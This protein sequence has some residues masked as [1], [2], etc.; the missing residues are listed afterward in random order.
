MTVISGI[1]LVSGCFCI[2][3]LL[4]LA[5]LRRFDEPGVAE[6]MAANALAFAAYAL[7]ALA[8]QLP[9]PLAIEGAN[10]VYV[11]ANIAVL[12]GF[13][14]FDGRKVPLAVFATGLAVFVMTL[15][16]FHYRY[17]SFTARIVT[18]SAFHGALMAAIAVTVFRSRARRH[19]RY[20][21]VFAGMTAALL[22]VVDVV[23]GVVH[24]MQSG[25]ANSLLQPSAWNVFFILVAALVLPALTFGAMMMVHDRMLVDS[26]SATS[27]DFLTGAATRSVFLERLEHE[28]ARSRRAGKKL[29]VLVLGVE[30]L[31]AIRK[32]FGN[33][34]GDQVM[35]AIALLADRMFRAADCFSRI[36]GDEFAVLLPETGDD[37]ALS[38][39]QRL[40]ARIAKSVFAGDAAPDMGRQPACTVS[41]GLAAMRAGESVQDVL[42]RA[43]SALHEARAGGGNRVACAAP[44]RG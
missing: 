27:R 28:W 43:K 8:R 13:L 41:I 23:R 44:E 29:S 35:V 10:G 37:A 40:R 2:L 3:M 11:A 30:G 36:G 31:P 22:A 25:E 1:F 19:S 17:E 9:P 6:W 16:L 26:A 38:I 4:V 24:V 21:Y 20:P 42:A 5:F 12:A 39:A 32:A 33:A 15:A 34:A 7:Y 14:R 18:F